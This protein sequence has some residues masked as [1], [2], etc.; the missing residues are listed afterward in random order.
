MLASLK[1]EF[2]KLLTVR[3]TYL[4]SGFVLVLV[5]FLSVYVYGYQQAAIK[6]DNPLFMSDA[7]YTMLGTFVTF[8]A[9]VAILLVAHEYRYNTIAYTLTASNSRLKVLGSKAIVVLAYA[10]VMGIFVILIGYFGTKIGLSLKGSTLVPQTI[11]IW[12]TIW[13]YASY[14]WIYVLFGLIIAVLVRSVVPA[15]AIYFLIPIAEQIL[16]LILKDNASFLPFQAVDAIAATSQPGISVFTLT[17]LTALSVSI[18][19]IIVLSTISAVLFVRRDA[20]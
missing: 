18:T 14:V 7:L 16:S 13:R 4:L 9:I 2:K 1:S 11:D 15:I 10:T 12:G 3:S 6:P 8:G 5:A 17:P 20:N 19:Y